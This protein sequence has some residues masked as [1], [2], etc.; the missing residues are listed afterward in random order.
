MTFLQRLVGELCPIGLLG[1]DSVTMDS[2]IK[3]VSF[4]ERRMR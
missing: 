3:S 4:A 2:I 1:H